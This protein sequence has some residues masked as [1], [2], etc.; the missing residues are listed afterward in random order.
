MAHRGVAWRRSLPQ[1]DFGA[2]FGV[3]PHTCTTLAPC[4]PT[5]SF[6]QV[7]TRVVQV[8]VPGGGPGKDGVG[9]FRDCQW[10]NVRAGMVVRVNDRE[11]IPA[12]VIPL[13]S[14]EEGHKC[15][16]ET[17]NIDGET[18]LKL[19]NCAKVSLAQD[20]DPLT[21]DLTANS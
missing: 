13:M 19:K 21:S 2:R 10:Q 16:I 4:L 20:Q 18:N 3:P 6:S 15:Y 14:S 9:E 12:D 1:P 7:N 5:S 8:L 11:E 17:A